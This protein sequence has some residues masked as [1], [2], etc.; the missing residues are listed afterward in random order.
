MNRRHTTLIILAT[1]FASIVF[2]PSCVGKKKFLNEVSRRATCDTTLQEIN[3]R[4]L[5]L[6]RELAQIKLQLAEKTGES[7][8]LREMQNKQ[9]AQINRLKLEV[10]RL[11]NQSLNQQ[12]TMDGALQQR[13][14]ELEASK[15]VIQSFKDVLIDQE[16]RMAELLRK[17]TEAIPELGGNDLTVEVKD[18][19]AIIS[20]SEKV[21]FRSGGDDLISKSGSIIERI[22]N[23]LQQYPDMDVL[24]LGHTDNQR[25]RVD[26]WN[27]SAMRAAALARSLT[28]DFGLNPNQ[29]TAAGKSEYKPKASNESA[30]GREQNRRTELVIS[31]QS[32]KIVRMVKNAN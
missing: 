9:D 11:T 23:V 26:N 28:K 19:K 3:S 14:Q 18:G 6:N 21:L 15:A 1:S 29:V 13:T 5:A 20:L 16:N 24:V 25:N 17:V 22:S 7:N 12:S 2:F 8:A 4:N 10:E 30:S 27:L 31:P 32:E